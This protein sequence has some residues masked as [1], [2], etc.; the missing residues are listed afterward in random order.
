MVHNNN[1]GACISLNVSVS[2][3]TVQG[4]MINEH[5]MTLGAYCITYN[6][7]CFHNYIPYALPMYTRV[8]VFGAFLQ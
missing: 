6:I 1:K 2:V 5:G 8:R 4:S 7:I 3:R